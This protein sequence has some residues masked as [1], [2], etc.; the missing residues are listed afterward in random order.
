MK[1]DPKKCKSLAAYW[2]QYGHSIDFN[3]LFDMKARGDGCYVALAWKIDD[4]LVNYADLARGGIDAPWE[5][6]N[7][8]HEDMSLAQWRRLKIKPECDWLYDPNKPE[9]IL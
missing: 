8:E 2:E 7:D 5:M 4:D 1:P 9:E 3:K 6:Q